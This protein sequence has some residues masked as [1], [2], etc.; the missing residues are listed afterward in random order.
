V[1]SRE[2]EAWVAKLQYEHARGLLSRG[3]IGRVLLYLEGKAAEQQQTD[4]ELCD[5]M[6]ADP[7]LGLLIRLIKH[8]WF[9]KDTPENL[10]NRV[11]ELAQGRP[12]LHRLRRW[13]KNAESMGRQVR[14]LQPWLLKA[15]ITIG[16]LARTTVCRS[17]RKAARQCAP[18]YRTT[19]GCT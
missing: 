11:N 10:L 14:S 19:S 18:G 4:L 16:T 5:A 9:L 3:D 13:P 8:G 6:E 12:Y 2:T 17:L 15:G 1:R 7:L